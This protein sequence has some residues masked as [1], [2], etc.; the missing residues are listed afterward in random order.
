MRHIAV[1]I[2]SALV[3]GTLLVSGAGAASAT[4]TKHAP[5]VEIKDISPNPVVV[6]AG[7]ETTA[8]FKVDATSD[9]DKVQLSVEP[10]DSRFRTLRAKDVKPLES[11]R[12]SVPF[13]ENDQDGK[14][15]AVAQGFKGDKVVTTDTAYFSVEIVKGKAETRIARFDASPSKVRQGKTIWFSG[16]LQANDDDHWK[17]VRGERVAIFYKANGSS[18]WKW[19]ASDRTGWK[20]QFE[21]RTRAWKSGQ[22]KA[23]FNGTDELDGATS[24]VEYVRVVRWHR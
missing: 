18:G 16:R 20:G 13:N 15:K 23:V 9:V 1:G 11:W 5:T 12:F 8:Y 4:T 2:I 22:Y 6:K 10:V 3:G 24:D 14:W 7:S 19:V 21:T 17:G